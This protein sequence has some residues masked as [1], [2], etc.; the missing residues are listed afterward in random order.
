MRKEILF[1]VIAGVIIGS[2]IAFGV[3]R[4]NKAYDIPK[5]NLLD[6]NNN[7]TP[8][9]A[10]N[11][12]PETTLVISQPLEEN[13]QTTDTVVIKGLSKPNA[14]IFISK[15]DKDYLVRA[16]KD[17]GF[18]QEIDLQSGLN[19]VIVAS[20]DESGSMNQELL[21][22]VYSSQFSL[23]TESA[24]ATD[25]ASIAES[26]EQKVSDV[27]NQPKVLIGTIAD[28]SDGTIQINTDSEK[29]NLV[30]VDKENTNVI[31]NDDEIEY[32]ELAIGDYVI[33]MG[34]RDDKEVLKSS[35][36]LVID[37]PEDTDRKV[38]YGTV[39]EPGK[40]FITLEI[41][42]NEKLSV[43]TSAKLTV[44]DG[45]DEEIEME[46]IV[47]GDVVVSSGV[48]DEGELYARII[49][50]ISS[51]ITITPEEEQD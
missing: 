7:P 41:G 43:N 10:M 20:V 35:R 4:A 50:I 12:K 27:V 51:P 21:E 38:M 49:Q 23:P 36:I 5:P 37:E 31:K 33:A 16:D 48:I 11:T 44:F 32:E 24:N 28:I 34:V 46:D 13:L 39:L 14:Y 17:G 9:A 3:Y 15:E 6:S 40:R 25:E 42:E 26:V 22:I 19:R 45:K 30:S 2:V 47:A 1:A 8:S 18:E 29:V